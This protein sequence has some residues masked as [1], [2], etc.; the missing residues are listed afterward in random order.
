[1]QSKWILLLVAG[2]TFVICGCD[3]EPTPNISEAPPYTDFPSPEEEDEETVP[4]VDLPPPEEWDDVTTPMEVIGVDNGD[5]S[6]TYSAVLAGY[7]LI[8]VQLPGGDFNYEYDA[9]NDTWSDD[10]LIHRQAGTTLSTV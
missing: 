2:L 7:Y 6:F 3:E 5:T 1:M 8:R 9:I 4:R 10:N